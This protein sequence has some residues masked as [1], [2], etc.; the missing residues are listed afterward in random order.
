M[1]VCIAAVCEAGSTLV[2]A[3][4]RE[5]G[6]GFT[7]AEFHDGKWH[8][9]YPDWNVGISGLV[10]N[11]TD[12]IAEARKDKPQSKTIADVQGAIEHAYRRA[13]LAKAE[14]EFLSGRGWTLKEFK[15]T[16][17]SRLSTTTYA[18]L[19][20][21]IAAYD[22]GADLI[23]AGFGEHW[24]NQVGP[25]IL[26]VRNPGVCVDHSKIGF[27]CVG[28][29]STAAQMSLFAREYSWA[30]SPEKAVY[31][32]LEAKIAAEHATGVGETTDIHLIRRGAGP[33][34][35]RPDT[36]KALKEIWRKL[37][38][39]EYGSKHHATLTQAN[40]FQMLRTL[41]R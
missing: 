28:S 24:G 36:M 8:P 30:F 39:K 21:R 4:D 17:S 13:R 10:T 15:E 38:P 37:S 31:C 16:G 32:V 6:V 14:G 40:E 27:W 34:S 3:A 19:D 18:T 29:G 25:S 5:M 26:T 2:L 41:P 35:I 9:L 1:T 33:I 7:S 22:F 11:A 23:V 12:V 20:A